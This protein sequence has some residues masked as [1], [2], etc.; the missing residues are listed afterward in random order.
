MIGIIV[1]GHGTFA[2][3]VVSALKLLAGDPE[4]LEAIDFG[5]DISVEALGEAISAAAARVDSGD[6]VLVLTD[7]RGGSPF[8]VS[9]R[10][11]MS[12]YEKME[13]VTGTN[14]PMLV[15]AF[16][17]RMMMDDVNALARQLASSG[18]EQVQYFEKEVLTAS[19]DD[20][21]IEMDDDDEIEID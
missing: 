11:A 7:L 3:G 6:G 18:K 15:E 20:D 9:T 5:G 13:V 17:S 8:N 2:T 19:D 10:I 16:M 1:T 21:D 4:A 14:L 12:G